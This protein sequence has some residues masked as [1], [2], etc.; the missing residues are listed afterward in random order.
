MNHGAAAGPADKS[1]LESLRKGAGL[2]AA[3]R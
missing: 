1:N 2:C 3:G